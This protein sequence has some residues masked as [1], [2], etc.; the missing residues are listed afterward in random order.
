MF[1][2]NMRIYIKVTPCASQNKIKKVGENEYQVRLTA[3]PI[4]GKA[5]EMLLKILAKHFNIAKSLIK[6]VGGK[7]AKIKIVDLMGL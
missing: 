4:K 3:S 1:L 6:I 7:S 2:K 5:N